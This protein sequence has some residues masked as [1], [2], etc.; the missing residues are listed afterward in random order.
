MILI[1]FI[2]DYFDLDNVRAVLDLFLMCFYHNE[3]KIF[4][5][6]EIFK[7]GGKKPIFP[8]DNHFFHQ[9]SS[10]WGLS[11][12]TNFVLKEKNYSLM[13]YYTLQYCFAMN[14]HCLTT[15]I[16]GNRK[17]WFDTTAIN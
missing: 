12:K 5:L 16:C 14:E 1:C 4:L 8:F 10:I 7:F 3:K 6:F 11:Y 15:D 2:K 13:C 9:A 17:K